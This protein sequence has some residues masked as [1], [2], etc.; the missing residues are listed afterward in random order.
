MSEQPLRITPADFRPPASRPKAPPGRTPPH[1]WKLPAALGAAALLLAGALWFAFTARPVSLETV[2][3]AAGIRLEGGMA[4]ALGGRYLARPGTY[5]VRAQA[6]G[7][8]PLR[9]QVAV[10][11]GGENRFRFE[12]EKLPGR[13]QVTTQPEG[14]AVEIDGQPAGTTPLPPLP[15]Q[16]GPHQ[17]VLRA[18]RH[19]MHSQGVEIE[20][21]DRLQTLEVALVPAWAEIALTSRPAGASLRVDGEEVGATP[22]RAEIGAGSHQLELR[23]PGY[24][25]WRRTLQVVANQPQTLPEVDLLRERG[26]LRVNSEPAGASVTVDGGFAGRAPL[27]AVLEP[28]RRIEVRASLAG[29][30]TASRTL[31]VASGAQ[32]ELALRLEPLLGEVR[33]R[34]TPKDAQLFVDGQ[35]RGDPDQTLSLLAVPHGIGVRK[36]GYLDYET[37]LTPQPGLVQELDVRLQTQAQAKAA[38]LPPRLTTAAG[39]QMVL[40][41]PGRL[42]LGAPRREQGRRSNETP[43]NVELTRPFYMAVYEVSNAEFRAFRRQHSSGIA[44]RTSL[45]NDDYPVV[46]VGWEDAVAYCNWLSQRQGLPPAYRGGELIEPIGTGYRLPSEAEWAWAA[47]FAGGR[48]LKYP[49]GAA[50]PPSGAAGNFADASARPLLGEVLAGYDDGY[51]ATAPAGSFRPNALGVFDLGGNVSEWMHDRYGET[52]LAGAALERDPFGPGSGT[53]RVVRGS[54]WRHSGITELRLSWRDSA[55]APRDDLGFRFVRYAESL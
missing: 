19:Q 21:L 30:R 32:Q 34:A 33:V 4:L 36:P 15:L 45:D 28:D 10:T 55:T 14:A 7:Y 38:R 11:A 20:G 8:H 3:E 6:P 17:L 39:Q 54:S 25:R 18:R 29:Y 52:L 43:R 35:P 27:T 24:E 26:T 41:R 42:T 37:T 50:M 13:L 53:A 16:A 12:L 51:P 44:A 9:R 31:A 47:R 40:V 48:N 22:L 46:R 5:T 1:G 49:W 2:P 23:L